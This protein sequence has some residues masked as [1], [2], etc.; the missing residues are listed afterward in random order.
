[1]SSSITTEEAMTESGLVTKPHLVFGDTPDAKDNGFV[2]HQNM[3][4]PFREETTIPYE[5]EQSG[6]VELLIYD[7]LGRI[8]YSVKEEATA[9]YNEITVPASSLNATGLVMYTLKANNTQR[10]KRMIID[11]E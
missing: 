8:L 10:T 2:L 3:P 9:G 6:M 1:M 4:N 5:L 11:K 7:V